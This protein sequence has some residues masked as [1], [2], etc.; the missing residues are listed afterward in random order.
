MVEKDYF[1]D[2]LEMLGHL[3]GGSK[4]QKVFWTNEISAYKGKNLH[5]HLVEQDDPLPVEK[6]KLESLCEDRH[7][8]G[9]ISRLHGYPNEENPI[10]VF[11]VRGYLD[12]PDNMNLTSTRCRDVEQIIRDNGYTVDK[13][14]S[15][16]ENRAVT[17]YFFPRRKGYAQFSPDS[18]T[19]LVGPVAMSGV[20][21]LYSR[22]DY[23][24]FALENVQ[25]IFSNIE[26][27]RE[28]NENFE[29]ICNE[30]KRNFD[31]AEGTGLLPPSIY[32]RMFDNHIDKDGKLTGEAENVQNQKKIINILSENGVKR[33]NFVLDLSDDSLEVSQRW[34]SLRELLEYTRKKGIATVL[35][36]KNLAGKTGRLEEYLDYIHRTILPG[37]DK[38]SFEV[39]RE[40]AQLREVLDRIKRS[41]KGKTIEIYTCITRQSRDEIIALAELFQEKFSDVEKFEWKINHDPESR[42]AIA[43]EVY[44]ALARKIRVRYSDSHKKKTGIRID[45]ALFGR[46]AASLYVFSDG[47]LG[48]IENSKLKIF[49]DLLKQN[50]LETLPA[51][52]IFKAVTDNIRKRSTYISRN[53]FSA[54]RERVPE[55]LIRDLTRMYQKLGIPDLFFHVSQEAELAGKIAEKVEEA[56]LSDDDIFILKIAIFVYHLGHRS[57]VGEYK[58]EYS[59]MRSVLYNK[60]PGDKNKQWRVQGGVEDL[61][62]EKKATGLP[63]N[64]RFRIFCETMAGLLKKKELNDEQKETARS[65]FDAKG[66]ALD[67]FEGSGTDIPENIRKRMNALSGKLPEDLKKDVKMLL[68]FYGNYREFLKNLKED[69]GLIR[70]ESAVSPE[71]MKMLIAITRVSSMFM[72]R[73]DRVVRE[74]MGRELSDSVPQAIEFIVKDIESHEKGAR[75]LSEAMIKLLELLKKRV[76]DSRFFNVLDRLRKEEDPQLLDKDRMF[77]RFLNSGIDLNPESYKSVIE[78]Y[79]KFEEGI[80]VGMYYRWAK[81]FIMAGALAV[82]S[83]CF[84]TAVSGAMATVLFL[85]GASMF[86]SSSWFFA[87]AENCKEAFEVEF[88]KEWHKVIVNGLLTGTYSGEDIKKEVDSLINDNGG[89]DER[90]KAGRMHIFLKQMA[91]LKDEKFLLGKDINTAKLIFEGRL[92]DAKKEGRAGEYLKLIGLLLGRK[93]PAEEAVEKFVDARGGRNKTREERLDIFRKKLGEHLKGYKEGAIPELEF[94]AIAGWVFDALKP[95]EKDFE[96]LAREMRVYQRE[97]A[98]EIVIARRR[99]VG[100]GFPSEL[101]ITN[102]E[103]FLRLP[104]VV[105]K[106]IE[107]QE[108]YEN[109]VECMLSSSFPFYHWHTSEGSVTRRLNERLDKDMPMTKKETLRLNKGRKEQMELR[110]GIWQWKEGDGLALVGDI[111]RDLRDVLGNLREELA[112]MIPAQRL[113]LTPKDE[114]HFTIT[115]IKSNTPG[116]SEDESVQLERAAMIG[117]TEDIVLNA[118][119]ERKAGLLVNF[120]L[121]RIRLINNGEIILTGEAG[122]PLLDHVRT[123]MRKTLGLLKKSIVHVTIGRVFDEGISED[124]VKALT[125]II[126]KYAKSREYTFEVGGISEDSAGLGLQI[127]DQAKKGRENKYQRIEIPDVVKNI[128]KEKSEATETDKPTMTKLGR[129]AYWAEKFMDSATEIANDIRF[130]LKPLLRRMRSG[131]KQPVRDLSGPEAGESNPLIQEFIEDGRMVEVFERDGKLVAYRMKWIDGYRPG[132]TEGV[133]GEEMD[134]EGLFTLQQQQNILAWIHRHVLPNNRRIRFRIALNNC[135]LGWEDGIRH[136]N[137]SHTGYR[138]GCIYIGEHLLA[139]IFDS[140]DDPLRKMILDEDEYMHLVDKD[141]DCQFDK[142]AYEKRLDAADKRIK[143]ISKRVLPSISYLIDILLGENL[144]SEFLNRDFHQRIESEP[145][146]P[147]SNLRKR[148]LSWRD[149]QFMKKRT[150]KSLHINRCHGCYKNVALGEE[151]KRFG[152][153]ELTCAPA[154]IF[155]KHIIAFAHRHIAQDT[156][157]VDLCM[158]V[159][160]MLEDPGGYNIYWA[161][162]EGASVKEHLHIHL[163]EGGRNFPI[164]E[165]PVISIA[166]N[167]QGED[168]VCLVKE[169]P[170]EDDP[171]T[172]FVVIGQPTEDPLL[173]AKRIFN[174]ESVIR[175]RGLDVDKV[176]TRDKK[177]GRVRAYIYPRRKGWVDEFCGRKKRVLGPVEMSGVFVIPDKGP[178]SE[179]KLEEAIEVLSEIGVPFKGAEA[180]SMIQAVMHYMQQ[181]KELIAV[182]GRKTKDVKAIIFDIDGVLS[183]VT[184][185]A[186]RNAQIQTYAD[187]MNRPVDEVRKEALAFYEAHDGI[188]SKRLIVELIEKAPKTERDEPLRTGE[189][190]YSE[191]VQRREAVLKG[192]MDKREALLAPHVLELFKKIETLPEPPE[193]YIASC[194]GRE[195]VLM[196]VE[197]TGLDRFIDGKNIFAV[198]EEKAQEERRLIKREAVRRIR[199]SEEL[200]AEQVVF[201][202]DALTIKDVLGDEA[203]IILAVNAYSDKEAIIQKGEELGIDY[204]AASLKPIP[205]LLEILLDKEKVDLEQAANLYKIYEDEIRKRLFNEEGQMTYRQGIE[206]VLRGKLEAALKSGESLD[207]AVVGDPATGKTTISNTIMNRDLRSVSGVSPVVISTDDFLLDKEERPLDPETGK[208]SEELLSKFEFDELLRRFKDHLEGKAIEFPVYDEMLRGRL[209]IGMDENGAPVVFIGKNEFYIEKDYVGREIY[210]GETE[211]MI[212]EYSSERII[213]KVHGT[214]NIINLSEG[215]IKSVEV[216]GKAQTVKYRR[217]TQEGIGR[218]YV[219]KEKGKV[220]ER[221]GDFVDVIQRIEPGQPTYVL[222]GMLVLYDTSFDKKFNIKMCFSCHPDITF[223]RARRRFHMQTGRKEYERRERDHMA[224][225]AK[226]RYSE[227]KLYTEP[228]AQRKENEDIVVVNTQTIAETIYVLHKEGQLAESRYA[229]ILNEKMGIDVFKLDKKLTRI[230]ESVRKELGEDKETLPV[231]DTEV[232]VDWTEIQI[233]KNQLEYIEKVVL[234]SKIAKLKELFSGIRVKKGPAYLYWSR[235]FLL[236]VPLIYGNRVYGVIRRAHNMFLK[237]PGLLQKQDADQLLRDILSNLHGK[238]AVLSAQENLIWYKY[239]DTLK[240]MYLE[241]NQSLLSKVIDKVRA[242]EAKGGKALLLGVCP[243]SANIIKAYF[244]VSVEKGLI[245]TFIATPRQVEVGGGYIGLDQYEFVEHLHNVARGV[246]YDGPI[247]IER[248]HGG[249]YKNPRYKDLSV[250]E[251]VKKAKETYRADIKAGFNIL[252]ID[253]SLLNKDRIGRTV[254]PADIAEYTAELIA[255]CENYRRKDKLPPVAYEIGSDDF[256]NG[257]RDIKA[258]E[259]FLMSLRSRLNNRN[260]GYVWNNILYLVVDTGTKLE[261][262]RQAGKFKAEDAE[263]YKK[264]AA[265]YGLLLKQHSLDYLNDE[266][267]ETVAATGIMAVNIG[268]EFSKA[269]YE[270]LEKLEQEV[271]R[272][273]RS[274]G[275]PASDFM[276]KVERSLAATDRWKRWV[277]GAQT[278]DQISDEQRRIVCLDCGR[279]TQG[280]KSVLRARDRLYELA[281]KLSITDDP[282]KFVTEAIKKSI[283]RCVRAFDK[284]KGLEGSDKESDSPAIV[285]GVSLEIYAKLERNSK[286]KELIPD[287]PWPIIMIGVD[288]S[289]GE[290]GMVREMFSEAAEALGDG[291]CFG[292]LIAPEVISAEFS[293]EDIIKELKP[294]IADFVSKAGREI[295]DI[296]RPA[297]QDLAEDAGESETR[298]IKNI[299]ELDEYGLKE[300]MSEMQ[301]PCRSYRMSEKSVSQMRVENAFEAF[302]EGKTTAEYIEGALHSSGMHYLAHYADGQAILSGKGPAIVPAGLEIQKRREFQKVSRQMDTYHDKFFIV[303]PEEGMTSE[304]KER[305]KTDMMDLWML[306]GVV[307]REDVF[308]LDRRGEAYRTS[309]LYL[310]LDDGN[311]GVTKTNAGFRCLNGSLEYDKATADLDLLQVDISQEAASNVNQYEVFV[312]LLISR[313]A[314]DGLYSVPGLTKDGRGLYIYLPEAKEVDLEDRIRKYYDRYV[315]EVR[316]KA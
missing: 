225:V 256:V 70:M 188:S 98:K 299:R 244:E 297:E 80:T 308:I 123:G 54:T 50:T 127:F 214:D 237:N 157:T 66:Y 45:Y 169:Y 30:I 291:E 251:A 227:K 59:A 19:S 221:A 27:L 267:L 76:R 31:E 73:L 35:S 288:P 67:V 198:S 158:E 119:A 60:Y 104:K 233:T 3:A 258:L 137:V 284:E 114:L 14:F 85:S 91:A 199:Q 8:K 174:V 300:K 2:V 79:N 263:A 242:Q 215:K 121:D 146:S 243:M 62:K 42:S 265:K 229:D 220:F 77:L 257:L 254:T 202:D 165:Y 116:P 303:A 7:G 241:E 282:E 140:P 120:N 286:L 314:G 113:Q 219:V 97:G 51:R 118:L 206:D 92:K 34:V 110:D 213:L 44:E 279:Y 245:P 13:V 17:V 142:N 192:L 156:I 16:G 231:L 46:E 112:E 250:E 180:S 24:R 184:L 252:H 125:E 183:Q 293:V 249:P 294:I 48:I 272:K 41:Y 26:T 163:I 166:K 47:A 176:F 38:I 159:L 37:A 89:K 239:I 207:V 203:I 5:V 205:G 11:A 204:V 240:E 149:P 246:R 95:G 132:K 28:T 255:D 253:C 309:E 52:G 12:S 58:E 53:D 94:N 312:N 195:S 138:D 224:L 130:I 88:I 292:A 10:A 129:V 302:H 103:A 210:F 152:N 316:V 287:V 96:K 280:D 164:E 75:W 306:D 71:K 179:L 128:M 81:W 289:E 144:K 33:I 197:A 178:Y 107:L 55:E 285:L 262:G 161:S 153:W 74:D 305:F 191:Y 168:V 82:F 143:A 181:E 20:W 65:M 100:G 307:S 39:N 21:T 277:S 101:E 270:A 32:F 124:E 177:T 148:Y 18:G 261:A 211:I 9:V 209:R 68:R 175:S 310:M 167:A 150:Y 185:G 49:A 131:K 295:E 84:F 15:E 87:I 315:K 160:R 298:N 290:G 22:R 200:K 126:K 122:N 230:A 301:R 226:R 271:N 141:F 145:I 154:P 269:E 223:E 117:K 260:M 275:E 134:I 232:T 274:I 276:D 194:R 304:E 99:P 78:E 40:T 155:F 106:I 25:N 136:L 247:L 313:E 217:E 196:F 147:D 139:S 135:T 234:E 108:M 43:E 170:T 4:K 56:K 218:R 189:E 64:E 264:L 311:S 281:K 57:R 1:Y 238:S 186:L 6:Y 173:V 266:D 93:H 236:A 201:I 23:Q 69:E 235:L 61:L 133:F 172:A 109:P 171:V 278:F 102:Y 111:S 90:G 63:K 283:L 296:K 273:A 72:N 29:K 193:L 268:P 212:K 86:L 105:K 259:R 36:I 248:D 162:K 187:I 222:D 228:A 115:I 83:G 151:R 216:T 208:P 190:Y 182:R